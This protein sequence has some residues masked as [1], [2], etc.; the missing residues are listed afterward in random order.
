MT[1]VAIHK[2]SLFGRIAFIADIFEMQWW[3][4]HILIEGNNEPYLLFLIFKIADRN[5]EHIVKSFEFH[6]FTLIQI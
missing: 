2:K 5:C 3:I 4:K 1:S 6:F